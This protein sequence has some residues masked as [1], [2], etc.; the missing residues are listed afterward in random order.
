MKY[1]HSTS[2]ASSSHLCKGLQNTKAKIS[3]DRLLSRLCTGKKKKSRHLLLFI[4]QSNRLDDPNILLVCQI[5]Q[6]HENKRSTYNKIWHLKRNNMIWHPKRTY[7]LAILKREEKEKELHSAHEI[8]Q[9]PLIPKE[10]PQ[11]WEFCS[12]K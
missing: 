11:K 6:I 12:S 2:P 5:I 10:V 1:F 9:N 3:F 8:L 7:R 4:K